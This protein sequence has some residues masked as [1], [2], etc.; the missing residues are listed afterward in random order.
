VSV[1][2][3]TE[4]TEDVITR[5][6]RTVVGLAALAVVAAA[7]L[8]WLLG[9]LATRPFRLLAARPSDPDRP[10]RFRGPG[11][12]QEAD[13]INGAL[14]K[15]L[16]QLDSEHTRTQQALAGARDFAALSA[17]ELRTPLTSMRTD[18]DLL[19]AATRDPQRFRMTGDQ[20]A[21]VVDR[22]A[23]GHR[24]ITDTLGALEQLAQG[25]L[26]DADEF[27][28]VDLT[29]LC[30]Q[31]VIE[32]LRQHPDVDITLT[33]SDP[34][35]IKGF[36]PGLRIAVDNGLTNA[37]IHGG[38]DVIVVSVRSE[39]AHAMIIIDDNGSGLPEAERAAVFARFERGSSARG[40]GTGLGLALIVQ[41]ALLHNGSAQLLDSPLGG[42]RLTMALA[43]G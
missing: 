19:R 10:D 1:G 16:G 36:A 43:D 6:H 27:E 28:V 38:A 14:S 2:L 33:E 25:E 5:R 11:G 29:D 35:Q 3:P 31:A 42:L 17:H 23:R 39:G 32:Q 37:R 30:D 7:I 12:A 4:P 22:L 41:Q 20:R 21:E 40:P 24:R 15:L 34:V 13:Q 26:A 18:L 8:G 9:G